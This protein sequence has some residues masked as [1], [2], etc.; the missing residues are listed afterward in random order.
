MALER[1]DERYAYSADR[2]AA[3]QAVELTSASLL[4]FAT[5]RFSIIVPY[6]DRPHFGGDA[7]RTVCLA[8][9]TPLS[10]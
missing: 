1:L 7:S 9:V 6:L 10:P 8:N 3:R 5:G 4:I 2:N